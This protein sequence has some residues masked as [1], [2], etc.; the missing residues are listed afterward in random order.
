MLNFQVRHVTFGGRAHVSE[1][2]IIEAPTVRAAKCQAAKLYPDVPGT[3]AHEERLCWSKTDR[4]KKDPDDETVI[5][6]TQGEPIEEEVVTEYDEDEDWN[7][8][9]DD[10]WG[11]DVGYDHY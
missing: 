4:R 1:T 11:G 9:D 6:L 10:I 5:Y 2:Q 7:W 8:D 3:W